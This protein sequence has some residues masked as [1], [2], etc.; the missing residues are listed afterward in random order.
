MVCDRYSLKNMRLFKTIK[1]FCLG[2][3][4][5]MRCF[6]WKRKYMNQS[7]KLHK[8]IT[9]P[10]CR[11]RWPYLGFWSNN[12]SRRFTA[13]V[14]IMRYVVYSVLCEPGEVAWVCSSFLPWLLWWRFVERHF[15]FNWESLIVIVASYFFPGI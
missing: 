15:G 2:Q 8:D 7:L 1:D 10:W 5:K 13:P 12:R 9:L 6:P 4:R 14:A 11:L 3:F